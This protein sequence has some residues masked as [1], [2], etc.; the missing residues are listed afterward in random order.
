MKYLCALCVVFA[1]VISSYGDC[2][3]VPGDDHPDFDLLIDAPAN[4]EHVLG[5]TEFD[6][7]VWL[8]CGSAGSGEFEQE[9]PIEI[10]AVKYGYEWREADMSQSYAIEPV[11]VSIGEQA[12]AAGFAVQFVPGMVEPCGYQGELDWCDPPWDMLCRE[13]LHVQLWSD[14]WERP[15]CTDALL[16]MEPGDA[17]LLYTVTMRTTGYDLGECW[18]WP[19]YSTYDPDYVLYQRHYINHQ[20]QPACTSGWYADICEWD[21]NGVMI[22]ITEGPE[23]ILGDMNCDDAVNFDDIVPFTVAIAGEDA[24]EAAYPDCNWLSG[25]VNNDGAVSFSDIQPFLALLD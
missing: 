24:Y 15:H 6:V 21:Y 4:V 25:D 8:V 23:F 2:I 5:G 19:L 12:A 22:E 16:L 17:V 18:L 10:P 20:G 14:S 3:Y 1:V 13:R 7:S 11:C 9:L